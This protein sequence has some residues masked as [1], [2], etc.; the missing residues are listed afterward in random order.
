ML[1]RGRRPDCGRVG[2]DWDS[3]FLCE[4]MAPADWAL[5]RLSCSRCTSVFRR[6]RAFR[7]EPAMDWGAKM[8]TGFPERGRRTGPAGDLVGRGSHGVVE[9]V[10]L[11]G[12]RNDHLQGPGCAQVGAAKADRRGMLA[13]VRHHD[14]CEYA[15]FPTLL[16]QD[17][18]S[19][20]KVNACAANQRWTQ[21][22]RSQV[23]RSENG[24]LH[25][26]ELAHV[27]VRDK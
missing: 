27:L 23:K 18:V 20:H 5:R 8:T 12:I 2:G 26:I 15:S 25:S 21:A 7:L 6:G 22:S 11:E 13:P 3:S 10:V 19:V 17:C 1:P 14:S 24:T 4:R 16:H 9:R